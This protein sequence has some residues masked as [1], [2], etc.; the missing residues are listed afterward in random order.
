[1]LHDTFAEG[2]FNFIDDLALAPREHRTIR[3]VAAGAVPEPSTLAMM[4]LGFEGLG[5]MARR[6]RADFV[7]SETCIQ[8]DC[9]M[10]V[11]CVALHRVVALQSPKASP[12]Q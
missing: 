3:D 2:G 1:V 9:P 4:I 6:P 5:F 12:S 10:A 8:R 11:F 7:R